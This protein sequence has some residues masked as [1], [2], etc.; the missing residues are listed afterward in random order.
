MTRLAHG[1]D[2]HAVADDTDD[3]AQGWPSRPGV[4]RH[5]PPLPGSLPVLS[6]AAVTTADQNPVPPQGVLPGQLGVI[7]LG[8]VILGDIAATLAD[9]AA[10]EAI[11]AEETRLEGGW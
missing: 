7:L 1:R 8:R 4:S 2:S 3:E 10:R 11:L 6:I 5:R 9:L